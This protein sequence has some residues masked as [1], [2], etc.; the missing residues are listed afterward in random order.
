MGLP[1]TEKATATRK[2][3]GNDGGN[4]RKNWKQK[5]WTVYEVRQ[6]IQ[7]P[8]ITMRLKRICLAVEQE[9]ER[10][11]IFGRIYYPLKENMYTAT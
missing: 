7:A 4:A 9:R 2:R 10:E 8:K 6:L 11:N 3:K 5:R 1:K